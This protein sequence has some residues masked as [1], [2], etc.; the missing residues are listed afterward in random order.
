M[1]FGFQ[2]FSNICHQTVSHQTSNVT[3][4]L[5]V[6]V[7]FDFWWNLAIAAVFVWWQQADNLDWDVANAVQALGQVE[8]VGVGR[9]EVSAGGSERQV[10]CE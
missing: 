5:E 1:L 7:L 6:D 8:N 4:H 9:K 3:E 10:Y 2:L